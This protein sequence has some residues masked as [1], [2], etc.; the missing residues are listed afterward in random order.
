MSNQQE[1]F[2]RVLTIFLMFDILQRK[3]TVLLTFNEQVMDKQLAI[4]LQEKIHI[5]IDKIVR[6]EY[7]MILLKSLFDSSFGSK[8]VFRGGTAL[9]LAYGSPRFSDDLDF[10]ALNSIDEDVFKKWCQE[11]AKTNSNLTVSDS[12]RKF[13]TLFALFKVI[14]PTLPQ[15]ISIKIEIS[16]RGNGW[17]RG[18]TFALL[19]I[20]SQV[21][22]I[23][24]MVQVAILEKIKAEK[25]TIQPPRIRDI[26][27]LWFIGQKLGKNTPMNFKGFR[28]REMRA[29]LHKYL[30]Q[31]DWRLIE[32]WLPEK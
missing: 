22:P 31:K 12:H 21:T 19:N 27:D 13:Y 30:S 24:V 15:A 18:K 28:I 9:R 7:E 29:E 2:K 23:T 3:L 8:L 16:T 11:V 25:L 26:F 20:S 6:E 10:S 17:I 4:K 14:D 32:S 5:S 1:I